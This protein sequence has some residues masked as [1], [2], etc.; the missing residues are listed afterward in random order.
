[1]DNCWYFQNRCIEP[2]D[3]PEG[4]IG[5]IYRI[6]SLIDLPDYPKGSLYIGRKMLNFSRR[7]KISKREQEATNNR[8]KKFKVVIKESDWRDYFGSSDVLKVLVAQYG[9]DNFK[10]E[11]IMFCKD[12]L[13]MSYWELHYQ[14]VEE[15]LF[16]PSFN[17]CIA[18]KFYRNKIYL[19]E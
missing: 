10:R 12:K 8:R 11:I 19:T 2:E 13:S 18:G 17:G 14:I 6:T 3:I 9:E 16:K 1:M 15:V 5:Y 4:S 7:A